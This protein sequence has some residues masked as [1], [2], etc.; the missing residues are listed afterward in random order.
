MLKC[1]GCGRLGGPFRFRHHV[2]ADGQTIR[3]WSCACGQR[4]FAAA[5]AEKGSAPQG[6]YAGFTV[7]YAGRLFQVSLRQIFKGESIWT[8][9]PWQFVIEGAPDSPGR[10][11]ISLHHLGK[12]DLMAQWKLQPDWSVTQILRHLKSTTAPPPELDLELTA[13]VLERIC[14]Q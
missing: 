10:R 7:D 3:A 14:G 4:F 12:G 6:N 13:R 9:G 1:P 2:S 5:G 11:T 8:L